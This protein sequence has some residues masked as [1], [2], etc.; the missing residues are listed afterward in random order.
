MPRR[1]RPRD[2]CAAV[3]IGACCVQ[4]THFHRSGRIFYIKLERS[5]PNKVKRNRIKPGWSRTNIV[6]TAECPEHRIAND[7]YQR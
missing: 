5:K 7:R 4:V 2:F 3:F 6:R 1:N